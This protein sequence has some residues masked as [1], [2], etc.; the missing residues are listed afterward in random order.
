MSAIINT[1]PNTQNLDFTV[2]VTTGFL[3]LSS[4]CTGLT[5][6]ATFVPCI[7]SNR[8]G[9]T[10]I[11]CGNGSTTTA[12]TSDIGQRIANNSSFEFPCLKVDT[13]W[14]KSGNAG[15]ADVTGYPK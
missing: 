12:P 10:M 5:A 9:G 3:Q 11:V 6:D 7:I 15:S 1:N 2:S 4:L 14:V 13:T 8:T